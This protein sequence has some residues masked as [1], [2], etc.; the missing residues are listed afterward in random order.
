MHA[1]RRGFYSIDQFTQKIEL[2]SGSVATVYQ[3]LETTT[4]A[5]VV[6]KA[7]H[8]DKMQPKHHYKLEREIECM[9]AMNG[10]FVA[11][12]YG[13][14]SD[15]KTV[16]LVMEYCEGG[17]LFKIMLKHGGRLDEHYVCVEVSPAA[18]AR[19]QEAVYPLR[20]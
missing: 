20:P 3:A 8:K 19:G 13:T 2:Y 4:G 16:Y 6:I 15:E 9:V 14:F 12:L 1:H 11:E 17:D 5:R 10:S 18:Q 7:Y